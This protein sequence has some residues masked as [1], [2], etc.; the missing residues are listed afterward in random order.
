MNYWFIASG[1]LSVMALAGHHF[2]GGKMVLK[3]SLEELKTEMLKVNMRHQFAVPTIT[4]AVFAAVYFAAAIGRLQ[5][6]TTTPLSALFIFYGIALFWCGFTS[7][8]KGAV[9]KVFPWILF[10]LAGGLGFMGACGG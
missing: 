5:A 10:L 9:M 6:E 7:S 8:E 4:F 3:P 2:V 1:V